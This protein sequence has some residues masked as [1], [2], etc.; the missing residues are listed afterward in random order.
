MDTP[1]YLTI[2]KIKEVASC[3]WWKNT[4]RKRLAEKFNLTEDQVDELRATPEYQKQVESLMLGQR[5][6]EDFEKCVKQWHKHHGNDAV[7]AFG[8]R[9]ALDPKV[10]PVMVKNVRKAHANI[11]AGKTEAPEYIPD[12]NKNMNLN[13]EKIIGSGRNSV[14]CYYDQQERER[15]E[16]KGEK[17]WEC[18]IGE[19]IR[20]LHTRINEQAD[21]VLPAETLKVGLHIKTDKHK[22]IERIIH[23]VL[24]VRGKHIV[25]TSRTD[26]FLTSPSEV[27]EI[28]N[29]I[30]EGSHESA[31]SSMRKS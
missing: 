4:S 18:N 1:E 12:P 10:V 16:S 2:R 13:P 9:M 30:G 15:A 23:D 7:S 14:Y 19:T 3:L 20:E 24:K 22:K 28:Y 5:S 11:A 25:E 6:A 17:I 8:K 29:S 21:T 26:W 31:S 27:E